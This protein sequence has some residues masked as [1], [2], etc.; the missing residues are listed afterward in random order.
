MTLY[1][2]LSVCLFIRTLQGKRLELSTP[3]SARDDTPR[4]AVGMRWP[5]SR[6]RSRSQGYQLRCRCGYTGR[7]S[8]TLFLFGFGGNLACQPS[9]RGWWSGPVDCPA[10]WLRLWLIDDRDIALFTCWRLRRSDT[11]QEFRLRDCL[12]CVRLEIDLNG[13]THRTHGR[14]FRF[15]FSLQLALF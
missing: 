3:K 6:Q 7:C 1:S 12:R 5:Y 8:C 11:T 14:A 15:S 4:Q 2:G 13:V 9:G 10:A